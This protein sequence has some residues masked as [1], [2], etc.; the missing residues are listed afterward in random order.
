MK[1]YLHFVKALFIL[2]F[3]SFLFFGSDCNNSTTQVT[4]ENIQGTWLLVSNT[5]GNQHD[6]CPGEVV[7]FQS[8][9]QAALTCPGQNTIF[10]S[11]S[12]S[13]NILSFPETGVKYQANLTNNNNTLDLTGLDF[14]KGRILEYNKINPAN[15]NVTHG[16]VSFENKNSSEK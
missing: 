7:D 2:V 15:S 3:I 10:R 14:I 12:V 6:I 13:N 4:N 5:G 8:D 11:Y 9:G 16:S 1:N